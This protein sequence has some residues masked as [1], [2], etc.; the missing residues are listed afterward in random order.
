MRDRA[1]DGGGARIR[2]RQA[3]CLVVLPGPIERAERRM[4]V[5]IVLDKAS[6]ACSAWLRNFFGFLRGFVLVANFMFPPANFALK[7]C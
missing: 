7:K 3:F 6:R 5:L 1:S 4:T 2:S